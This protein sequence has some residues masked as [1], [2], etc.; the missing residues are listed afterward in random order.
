MCVCYSKYQIIYTL[1]INDVDG[2]TQL[3]LL[4]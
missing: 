2:F 3:R 1:V 4:S